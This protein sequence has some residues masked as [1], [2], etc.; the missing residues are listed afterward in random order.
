MKLM[1]KT[2]ILIL[3]LSLLATPVWAESQG[4]AST[5]ASA[6]FT[7]TTV[8]LYGQNGNMFRI[9]A[10]VQGKYEMDVI[11]VRT[12]EVQRSSNGTSSWTTVKT[13][14]S[15]SISSMLKN[16]SVYHSYNVGYA[17]AYG[18]YYRA[19]ITFYAEK[20]GNVGLLNR[21]TSVIQL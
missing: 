12:I 2:I 10:D 9:W 13:F 19:Y 20:D 15:S 18:Y 7:A 17:G 11:G 14:S 3:V 6:F 4:E 21:Y 8:F 5:Y 16:N 1:H